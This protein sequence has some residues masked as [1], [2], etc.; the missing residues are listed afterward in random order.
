MTR[1]LMTLIRVICRDGSCGFVEDSSLG[2]FIR[3]GTVVS[4]F[5]TDLN[6]W[7]D[8]GYNGANKGNRDLE[9]IED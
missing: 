5:R 6:E 9:I 1:I 3:I 4:F 8:L 7:V 2:D